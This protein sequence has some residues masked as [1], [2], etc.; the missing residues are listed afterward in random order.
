MP[1][2]TLDD[3][4]ITREGLHALYTVVLKTKNGEPWD[5]TNFNLRMKQLETFAEHTGLY[6]PDPGSITGRKPK[7]F[8]AMEGKDFRR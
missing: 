8:R 3:H 7:P 6:D 4:P 1:V 2:P 5:F